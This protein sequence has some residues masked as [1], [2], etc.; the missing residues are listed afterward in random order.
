MLQDGATSLI[1]GK[2]GEAGASGAAAQE[3]DVEDE[4]EEEEEEEEVT[5][6]VLDKLMEIAIRYPMVRYFCLL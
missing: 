6:R 5:A 3:E 4:E 2:E 1:G